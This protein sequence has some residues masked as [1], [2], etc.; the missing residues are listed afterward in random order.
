MSQLSPKEEAKIRGTHCGSGVFF[1][2]TYFFS[3]LVL[4]RY[5]EKTMTYFI[6]QTHPHN[7]FQIAH[8]QTR[9]KAYLLQSPGRMS[10]KDFIISRKNFKKCKPEKHRITHHLTQV[11]DRDYAGITGGFLELLN[12][13]LSKLT[14]WTLP[15]C[16][17]ARKATLHTAST[18]C[19]NTP[20]GS[21]SP[22]VSSQ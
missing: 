7:C 21:R 12:P 17:E 22:G 6:S 19:A 16:Q 8:P 10:C 20:S 4:S 13:V 14:H 11:L 9:D 15:T 3:T 18:Q 1:C 2:N 5:L